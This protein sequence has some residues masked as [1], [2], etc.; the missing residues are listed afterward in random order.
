MPKSSS[1]ST[2]FWDPSRP[3]AR[4]PDADP[5]HLP[6]PTSSGSGESFSS[7]TIDVLC[8]AKDPTSSSNGR[9]SVSLSFAVQ[10]VPMARGASHRQA[11]NPARMA[12]SRLSFV[13]EMEVEAPRSAADLKGRSGADS[14]DGREQSDVGPGADRCR[15]SGEIGPPLFS[16]DDQT[17][18]GDRHRTET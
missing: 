18:H 7:K 13:L 16:E 9:H 15:T 5:A 6:L 12:P 14:T 10:L 4:F 2:P 17:L 1:R 8:G 3:P 11:R